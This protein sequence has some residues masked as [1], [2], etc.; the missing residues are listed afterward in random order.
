[1]IRQR[2]CL[3][4]NNIFITIK[5]PNTLLGLSATCDNP[6]KLCRLM[7]KKRDVW[8]CP[9][10]KRIVPIYHYGFIT[11]QSKMLE[12]L[13]NKKN[14]DV[15][16]IF[17]NPILLKKQNEIFSEDNYHL[18]KKGLK[19]LQDEKCWIDKYFIVNRLLL[20][21]KNNQQLPAISCIFKERLL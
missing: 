18:L 16:K 20:F 13:K 4:S 15:E 12:H 8:L 2:W 1:M 19:Y 10:D 11:A 5:F 21:L 17:E 6:T 9:H 7:G 3:G 14:V